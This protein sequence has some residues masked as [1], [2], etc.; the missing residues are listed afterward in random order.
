[1]YTA[2]RCLWSGYSEDGNDQ[3]LH[4]P[5]QPRGAHGQVAQLLQRH[6]AL[7]VPGVTSSHASFYTQ[8]QVVAY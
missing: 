2:A 7:H 8:L 5:L 3:R 1:M 6:H 4:G